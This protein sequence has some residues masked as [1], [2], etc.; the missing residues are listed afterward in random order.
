MALNLTEKIAQPVS[1]TLQLEQATNTKIV[2]AE[3]CIDPA[4]TCSTGIQM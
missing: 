2:R 1:K 4:A 3:Y